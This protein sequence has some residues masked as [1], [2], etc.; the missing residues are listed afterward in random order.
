MLALCFKNIFYRSRIS[1]SVSL[2]YVGRR[3]PNMRALLYVKAASY[4]CLSASFSSLLL[5]LHAA[6]QDLL[7][8][9]QDVGVAL[10]QDLLQH[11]VL[12]QREHLLQRGDVEAVGHGAEVAGAAEAAARGGGAVAQRGG[13]A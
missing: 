3:S 2:P 1:K 6:R 13:E 4:W 12:H 7:N 8:G 5:L 9:G 10:G 11:R